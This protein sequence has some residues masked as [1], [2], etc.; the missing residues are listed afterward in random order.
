M[1][2]AVEPGLLGLKPIRRISD[3]HLPVTGC[4]LIGLLEL[5]FLNR[6][7]M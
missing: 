1:L 6:E 7:P 2:L 3:S 5:A 4:S